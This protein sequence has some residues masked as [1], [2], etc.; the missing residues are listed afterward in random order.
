M[1]P[2][3]FID[4]EEGTVGLSIKKKLLSRK[5]LELIS[6][7]REDKK[8]I[9][10]KKIIIEKCDL[11]I[12][13]LPKAAAEEMVLELKNKEVKIIDAS[14]AHR[15]CKDW[16]YGFAE[17]DKKQREKIKKAQKTANPGCYA[18]GVIALLR[19][20]IKNSI[21]DIKDNYSIHAISGYSGGGKNLIENY[22]KNNLIMGSYALEQNHKHLPEIIKYSMLKKK[23]YFSPSVGGFFN[24]MSVHIPLFKEQLKYNLADIYSC[25]KEYYKNENFIK[26][27]EINKNSWLV[28]DFLNP[29]SCNETNILKIA[30]YG[31]NDVFSLVAVLDNLGKGASGAAIQ[32]LNLMLGLEEDTGL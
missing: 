2:K 31:K 25:Y 30:I 27:G 9:K 5:D 17:L 24:G 28:G 10:K 4:G 26:I 29:T 7:K 19:P 20:L 16:V 11:I 8:N 14:P 23:P 3:I 22:K 15:V 12:L 13:C 6:I 1:K 21:L 18:T 32:N